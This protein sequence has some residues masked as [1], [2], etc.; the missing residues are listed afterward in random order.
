M[1]S[2]ERTQRTAMIILLRGAVGMRTIQ[3]IQAIIDEHNQHRSSCLNLVGA[4]K[5][6]SPSARHFLT[7]DFGNRYATYNDDVRQRNYLGVK[8]IAEL[9]AQAHELAKEL[10]DA[11]CVDLRPLGGELAAKAV[12]VGLTEPGDSVIEHGPGYGGHG[13]AR[14]LL[15]GNL[16]RNI[17]RLEYIPNDPV[18]YDVDLKALEEMALRLKPKLI[19]CGR[20]T[21]LFFESL[22]EVRRI[23]DQ[24][25]AYLAYDGAHIMGLVA[26]KSYP[27]PLDRG[28]H[29]LFGCTRKTM[30]AIQGGMILC[31]DEA[32]YKRIRPSLYPALQT[33]HDYSRIPALAAT[34]LE[35]IEFGQAYIGQVVSNAQRLGAELESLGL[36][37]LYPEKDYTQCHQV[38]LDVRDLGK[39]GELAKRL[40]AANIISGSTAI[41]CDAPQG[42]NGDT[43]K[44]A[45]GN[46]GIRIGVQEITRMGMK[47][48]EM[49]QVAQLL[50]Q[51]LVD[52]EVDKTRQMVAELTQSF[53]T[54]QYCF[55]AGQKVW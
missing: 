7:C 15:Y 47:H 1:A 14:R 23:A 27:N 9:E 50:K 42:E 25:G 41:P 43:P 54:I 18:T 30:Q 36:R 21:P 33:N 37:P 35:F 34:F 49:K 17:Y 20:A 38:V 16:T 24:V 22:K 4:E 55:D 26:G 10:F 12:I 6:V 19:I 51:V 40:E 13:V 8:Y 44:P 46:S 11:K 28:A 29:V 2:R 3:D 5:M 48:P 32:L 53:Q 39:A 31:N 52:N 45:T